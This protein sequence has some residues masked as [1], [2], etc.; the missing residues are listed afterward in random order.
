MGL[1]EE[2]ISIIGEYGQEE[3][4]LKAI[5]QQWDHS[6]VNSGLRL[7]LFGKQSNNLQ[8][9]KIAIIARLIS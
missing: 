6:T 5:N 2:E 1:K 8:N 4:A 7:S 9:N 3:L